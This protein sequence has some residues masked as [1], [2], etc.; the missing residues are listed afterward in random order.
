MKNRFMVEKK[1]TNVNGFTAVNN[2]E[3][4]LASESFK[5][6]RLRLDLIIVW[7]AILVPVKTENQFQTTKEIRGFMAL[8]SREKEEAFAAVNVKV[9]ERSVC[10]RKPSLIYLNHIR[11]I[12][13]VL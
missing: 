8:Y 7:F 6:D 11:P 10:S 13:H 1:L 12:T 5:N 2:D 9:K 3:L 4:Y